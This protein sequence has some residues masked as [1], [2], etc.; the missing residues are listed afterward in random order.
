MK[1]GGWAR[2]TNR[3]A[4]GLGHVA[5]VSSGKDWPTVA[6]GLGVDA[7]T[8]LECFV[9]GVATVVLGSAVFLLF[10][11]W[12]VAN[13]RES[14][15]SSLTDI[16]EGLKSHDQTVTALHQRLQAIEKRLSELEEQ[17]HRQVMT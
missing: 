10:L 8:P 14:L 9:A 4:E 1:P 11:K 16:E 13:Q 7:L 15:S 3:A 6:R 17:M 2:S 12:S 5:A